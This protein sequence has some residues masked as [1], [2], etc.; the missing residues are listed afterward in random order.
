METYWT[1]FSNTYRALVW[2]FNTIGA[3]LGFIQFTYHVITYWRIS[4]GF[5]WC[6]Q[7]TPV[8]LSHTVAAGIFF[9][10]IET[11]MTLYNI[12][13]ATL[14]CFFNTIRATL[15]CF[16]NTIR[17]TLG[18]FFNT[19]S[20]TLI[21]FQFTYQFI[22]YWRFSLSFHGPFEFA[23]DMFSCT[24]EISCVIFF[25]TMETSRTSYLNI[26]WAILLCFFDTGGTLV[27][28]YDTIEAPLVWFCS[29]IGV[30]LEC[31]FF[32][33]WAQLRCFFNAI[34]ETLMTIW[35]PFWWSAP[36]VVIK[37]ICLWFLNCCSILVSIFT[38]VCPANEYQLIQINW[39]RQYKSSLA[40]SGLTWHVLLPKDLV[41]TLPVDVLTLPWTGKMLT[42]KLDNP[43]D[44][45]SIIT[46]AQ[47]KNARFETKIY[48]STQ[49]SSNE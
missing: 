26:F 38:F 8:M 1:L 30:N 11:V 41:I 6:F 27:G 4:L 46:L 9:N 49:N 28:F 19:I 12:C 33:N 25:Y 23:L 39:T 36:L 18:C 24:I 40:I 32:S 3:N 22:S 20:V 5:H 16:F 13:R 42:T 29:T 15:V 31:V 34:W 17:T 10:A 14:V 45:Q 37:T 47:H 48:G 44:T 35:E 43:V 2:Y 7:I 21:F